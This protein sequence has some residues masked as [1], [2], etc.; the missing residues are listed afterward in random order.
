MKICFWGNVASAL[1][2]KTI[3]GGEL[4]IA[5]LA[6]ALAMAG[7]EVV[8]IDPFSNESFITDEGVKLLPVPDFHKGL[9]GLRLFL[10]RIPALWKIFKEQKADYYYICMRFYLHLI[11]YFA[12]KKTGGKFILAIASDLDVLSAGKKFKYSYKPGLDLF[13]Y[14]TVRVP[15]DLVFNYLLKKSDLILLQHSGQKLPS[16]FIKGKVA[17]FPNLINLNTLPIAGNNSKDYFIHVGSMTILKGADKLYELI[18]SIDRKH[19]F[20]IVGQPRDSQAKAIFENLAKI[21]NVIVK[22]RLS[23]KETLQL[24]A[25][26]KALINTSYYEG[27]PNIF[28]EAWATGVPVI[29]LR[30]NPGNVFNKY[31]L[32]VCCDGNLE[33]MKVCIESDETI[34]LDKD[35]MV[36][37][38]KEFHDFNTASERFSSILHDI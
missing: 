32:G 18:K 27:F 13:D 36:A 3:G 33:R 16:A 21:E 29:S 7:H 10:Y 38:V 1:R 8:V 9:R 28:I 17:I 20:I 5:V 37:Y 2:G 22:G 24:I 34:R 31:N 19:T 35:R 4:Q 15:G 11:P 14:L 25:N 12:A 23:H 6:K 30:V 26:A